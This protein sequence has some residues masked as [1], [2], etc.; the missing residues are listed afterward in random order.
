[1]D[2]N[3]LKTTIEQQTGIPAA[4]LD[5]N[6]ADEIITRARDLL[7]LKRENEPAHPESTKD[8]FAGWISAQLW[9]D[10]PPDRATLALDKIADLFK[11]APAVFDGGEID[12]TGIPDRTPQEAFETYIKNA[13]AYNPQRRADGWIRII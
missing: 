13:V 8:Q 2:N 1:M 9:Q 5:G 3:E 12:H 10:P 4:L 11:T 7:S 6:S